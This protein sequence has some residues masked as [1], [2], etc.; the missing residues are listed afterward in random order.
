[1]NERSETYR[2]KGYWTD[3]LLIDFFEDAVQKFPDKTAVVDERFGARTY[4]ELAEEVRRLAAALQAKGVG[5]GDRFIVALPNWRHVSVFTLALCSIGAVGVHMPV[6]GREHEFGGVL[7]VTQAKG[8][9]VPREFRGFDY[10]SMV[11]GLAGKSGALETLV[12]VGGDPGHPGWVPF[13]Q[14]L[15]DAPNDPPGADARAA[16]ADVTSLLFT[17]GASGDPKGVVHS[18]NTLGALNTTV[19]QAC[20]LGPED[21]MFMGAPLGYSA[22]LVHGVRLAIY[23]GAKL[24]LLESWNVERALEIMARENATYTLMTPTLL[25]DLLESE[26]LPLY[27]DRLTLRILFCGGTYVTDELVHSAHKRLP[28]TFTAAFW[29]MTEGIGAACRPGMPDERV[30]GT[31][32]RPFPEKKVS[33]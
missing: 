17:S 19:A 23:L 29:G 27:A 7:R 26:A 3:R 25:R 8:I 5:R 20:G 24:A 21:V 10:V 16:A 30:Y 33:L 18:S 2:T 11:G 31:A 14:L 28:A 4:R 1:V 22:G 12:A 13:E 9:V 6:S 32:G 15:S